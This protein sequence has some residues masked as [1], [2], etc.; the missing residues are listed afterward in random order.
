MKTFLTLSLLLASLYTQAE[1]ISCSS[2]WTRGFPER[3]RESDAGN[4]HRFFPE[5]TTP[6]PSFQFFLQDEASLD[7]EAKMRM[8]WAAEAIQYSANKYALYASVPKTIIVFSARPSVDDSLERAKTFVQYFHLG[9]ESCP[10]VLYPRILSLPKDHFYQTIAH[11]LYHCAQKVNFP[12]KTTQAVFNEEAKFWFEGMAQFM[13]NV[14]YPHFDL[15]YHPMFGTFQPA[16]AFFSQPQ[17]YLSETFFQSY[18]W[19]MGNSPEAVHALNH[20]FTGDRSAVEE[21][22]GIPNIGEAVHR[23]GRDL[24]FLELKD[25]SGSLVPLRAPKQSFVVS[26]GPSTRVSIVF[27]DFGVSPFEITFPK[28]G[29]YRIS[30]LGGD[31]AKLSLREQ[32]TSEWMNHFETEFS[33]KCHQELKLEGIYT[34]ASSDYASNRV[35]LDISRV[36][37]D[38]ECPC[39][40]ESPNQ[41]LCLLGGWAADGDHLANQFMNL[42]QGTVALTGHTGVV[43]LTFNESGGMIWDYQ[44]Y[45]IKGQSTRGR[46]IKDFSWLWNGVANLK[47]SAKR[48][49]EGL[50]QLCGAVVNNSVI[51]SASITSRGR[52]IN[53]PPQVLPYAGAGQTTYTCEGNTLK[54]HFSAGPMIDPWVFYRE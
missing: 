17:P 53:L 31:G 18:M 26:E 42:F 46:D 50:G 49:T 47:F 16:D 9:T 38:L 21:A 5:S 23:Y 35:R 51:G 20:I 44:S 36:E 25:S 39:D 52:T 2:L 29:K 54:F 7:A 19:T 11:E 4:C 15:E 43:K 30:I 24:S 8:E 12:D 45:N 41:D 28:R 13:S 37:N 14:V 10:I 3:G 27:S 1:M 32:G 34:R 22:M 33:T 48:N 6:D 40:T